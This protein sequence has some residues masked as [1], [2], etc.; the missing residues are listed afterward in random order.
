MAAARSVLIS[1]ITHLQI[2]TEPLIVSKMRNSYITDVLEELMRA[3]ILTER[4]LSSD[5]LNVFNRYLKLEVRHSFSLLKAI[6]ARMRGDDIFG[7]RIPDGWKKML[8]ERLAQVTRQK[9]RV[10]QQ[11]GG[12]TETLL[13]IVNVIASSPHVPDYLSPDKSL[14]YA[15]QQIEGPEW[16]GI[17]ELKMEH[18]G[19]VLLI[20]ESVSK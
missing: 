17:P 14:L 6:I 20:A 11:P 8:P 10:D 12:V 13:Q 15:I 18:I 3:E 4:H 16:D 9:L 19:H 1:A 5:T 2:S 7:G